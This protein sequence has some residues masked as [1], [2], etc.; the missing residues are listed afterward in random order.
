LSS[1]KGRVISRAAFIGF[2]VKLQEA[3]TAPYVSSRSRSS[4]QY[5]REYDGRSVKLVSE[6]RSRESIH[7][8]SIRIHGMTASVIKWS[9]FTATNSE[10]PGT[11]PGATRFCKKWWVWNGIHSA[12]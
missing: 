4:L 11:I 10:I 12:S 5:C 7:S 8:P 6:S 2:T 9:E 1:N 3:V